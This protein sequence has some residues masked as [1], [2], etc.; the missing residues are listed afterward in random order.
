MSTTAQTA[1]N[2]ANAQHSTG[3]K[4]EQGKAIASLNNLRHGFNGSFSVMPWESQDEFDFLFIDLRVEYKPV[5]VTETVLVEKMAQAMWLGQRAVL[6]QQ[7]CFNPNVP[8]CDNEKQLALYLRYQTTHDRAFHKCLTQLLKLRAE[9]RKE[10]IGFESQQQKN[11]D[12]T[13]REANENRKQELHRY[14]VLLAEAK[15]DHQD[16]LNMNLR[17]SIDPLSS[18]T[19]RPTESQKAA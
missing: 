1:A 16:L 14:N 17:H 18:P 10:E 12:Q 19:S 4:T 5:T 8:E 7:R 11:A 3:P 2:Q 9:K 6:L 13:R 15:A